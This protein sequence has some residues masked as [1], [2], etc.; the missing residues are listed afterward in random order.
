MLICER[1]GA[2]WGDAGLRVNVNYNA[3]SERIQEC[4]PWCI[5]NVALDLLFKACGKNS[6]S[7]TKLRISTFFAAGSMWLTPNCLCYK[8]EGF[9]FP[10]VP[11]VCRLLL[12]KPKELRH[13]IL[14]DCGLHALENA[15]NGT[16]NLK[17]WNFHPMALLHVRTVHSAMLYT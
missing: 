1:S 4:F 16:C 5:R 7:Q 11:V 17:L 8:W 9:S 6:W 10:S 3:A 15:G 2:S 13:E 14:K 12:Q